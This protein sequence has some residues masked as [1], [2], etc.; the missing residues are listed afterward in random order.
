MSIHALVEAARRYT[1]AQTGAGPFAT[2][3]PGLIIHRA[4]HTM[5]PAYRVFKPALCVVAQGSKWAIVGDRR[6]EYRAGQ[7]LVAS[8]EVPGVGRIVEARP[9]RP[10]LGVIIE[11]DPVI[12]REALESLPHPPGSGADTTAGVFVADID[13]PLADCVL[14]MIRLLDTP[15]AIPV[16]R[17]LIL[18][19]LCYWLLTGPH[20]GAVARMVLAN[21]HAADVVRA[22]HVLRDRF[23]EPIRVAELARVAGLSP[24]AFHRQFR[25]ATSLTPLQ[26]QKQ[27]RL[28][29][30]RRL[31]VADAVSVELAASRVGYES[32][33]QFSREY[34]RMFG[35]PPRRDA[36]A[37]RALSSSRTESR[38]TNQSAAPS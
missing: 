29:E 36:V 16:L 5:R 31:L 27:L 21:A 38:E 30:A 10:Y 34:A 19:E 1:D 33:S 12:M 28:L 32:S 13:G 7:A 4:D 15:A 25:A 35:A 20:G 6:L 8:I 26:Y 37:V 22:V 24:S 17:P 2:A 11:F 3:V 9:D 18:R 14:R 23:T